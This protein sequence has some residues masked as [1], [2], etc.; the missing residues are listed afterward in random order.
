MQSH[1]ML[2]RFHAIKSENAHAVL[3]QS[4]WKN[5]EA[6]CVHRGY[7]VAL[8]GQQ[9]IG[10]NELSTRILSLVMHVLVPTF[11]SKGCQLQGM[12]NSRDD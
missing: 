12:Q 6:V 5:P 9:F 4:V 8:G 10:K 3:P 1:T 2:K 7:T 11:A